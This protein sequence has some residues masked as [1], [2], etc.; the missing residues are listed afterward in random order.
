MR[1]FK[2]RGKI[3][4]H[5]TRFLKTL[6]YKVGD[7][8]YGE[9]ISTEHDD[10]EPD[11]IHVFICGIRVDPN[12]V[13]Q[14]IGLED[15]GGKYKAYEG[16]IVQDLDDATLGLVYWDEEEAGFKI[17][18]EHWIVGIEDISYY[19]VIGNKWDNPELT[20]N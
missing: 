15:Y 19:Q 10:I 4:D 9:N 12:T 3:I 8:I 1:E 7:W 2:F 11:K 17:S 20:E 13:G 5:R 16:D 6:G 14:C 18:F